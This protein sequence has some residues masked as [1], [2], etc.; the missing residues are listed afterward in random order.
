MA[1]N[2]SN[3]NNLGDQGIWRSTDGGTT[4]LHNSGVAAGLPQIA[5]GAVVA[6][7]TNSSRYYTAATNAASASNR[8]VYR[9]DNSGAS[10]TRIS[11]PNLD[12]IINS[13]T[14]LIDLSVSTT[15]TLFAGV[16]DS[17][18]LAGVFRTTYQGV[19]WTN[20]G[21]PTTTEGP[22]ATVI[23]IHPGGQGAIHFSIAAH[24]TDANVVYLGGDRQPL[25]VDYGGT[26]PNSL[27]ANN[28]TGRLFRSTVA[29]Q[30]VS[31]THSGTASTVRRTP[32]RG[33]WRWI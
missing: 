11:D 21:V 20:F 4:F 1:V 29:G 26:S 16:I 7:P 2:A 13:S 6:D 10:W 24:P 32:I 28:F 22:S 33:R 30:W 5:A 3:T 25:G 31:L 12:S 15:G 9:T 19:N 17:G 8:G 18:A 23:G 14:N 27:G